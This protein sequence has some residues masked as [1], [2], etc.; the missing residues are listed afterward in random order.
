L[1]RP[2]QKSLPSS[3]FQ[4]GESFGGFDGEFLPLFSLLE[5]EE[6]GRFYRF[7]KG[8]IVSFSILIFSAFSAIS[9]VKI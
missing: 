2:C 8:Q 3:L 6:E 1:K 7:S 4:R 9:A 5:K